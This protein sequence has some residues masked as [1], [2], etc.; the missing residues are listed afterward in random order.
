[1][2]NLQAIKDR[3]A[4]VTPGKWRPATFG[5]KSDNF[6]GVAADQEDGDW[7]H[8][9][10]CEDSISEDEDANAEFLGHSK[11]DIEDLIT[12]VERLQKE[13][14]DLEEVEFSPWNVTLQD[15][16]EDE[17]IVWETMTLDLSSKEA[18]MGVF[19]GYKYYLA[20]KNTE[21][22]LNWFE[23]VEHC[24]TLE[25]TVDKHGQTVLS[26][27]EWFLPTLEELKF[28]YENRH[29]LFSEEGFAYNCY[30]SCNTGKDLL[31]GIFYFDSRAFEDYKVKNAK[32][33]VRAVRKEL[34]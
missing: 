5:T 27:K 2:L 18:Y 22:Y 25:A 19:N 21:E 34:V 29:N 6:R 33:F 12:E 8:I 30:W 26:P 23:A 4:K 9:C 15:G 10:S 24:R 1:M 20:P 17:E 13:L 3:L 28:F 14:K 31:A 7:Y 11:Q 32:A 16:L